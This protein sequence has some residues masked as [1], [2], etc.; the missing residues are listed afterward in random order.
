MWKK[1]VTIYDSEDIKAFT[2]VWKKPHGWM[3]WGSIAGVKKGPCFFWE[4]E[5]GG[6][7]AEKY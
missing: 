3:F 1:W 5:Y 4:K 7:T 6:I 2:L